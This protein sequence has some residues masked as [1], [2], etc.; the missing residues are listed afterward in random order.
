M[1]HW[2]PPKK[3]NEKKD[4]EIS[5]KHYT[6]LSVTDLV[7]MISLLE[8]DL[9]EQNQIV[10]NFNINRK[11]ATIEDLTNI[12][13]VKLNQDKI[14]QHINMIKNEIYKRLPSIE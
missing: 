2:P 6:D 7:S 4:D 1:S 13:Q 9:L 11:K 8:K 12:D 3:Q 10:Y 14:K 5:I